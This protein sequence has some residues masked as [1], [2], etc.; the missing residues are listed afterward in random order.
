M[1]SHPHP[2]VE[3]TWDLGENDDYPIMQRFDFARVNSDED[4]TNGEHFWLASLLRRMRTRFSVRFLLN[5]GFEFKL[6]KWAF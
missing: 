2:L 1:I 3:V 5:F 4:A 6:G